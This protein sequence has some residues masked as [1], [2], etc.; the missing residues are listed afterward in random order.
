MLATQDSSEVSLDEYVT[1]LRRRWLWIVITPLIL[2]GF[3]LF[4]DLRAEPVYA[5]NA[6]ML[7]RSDVTNTVLSPTAA[8][9]DAER[10]LQNELSVINSRNVKEAVAE[11]YGKPISVRTLA[12]GEDDVIIL[13]AKASTGK[14]AAERAN[15]YATTYQSVR[16]ETL[17]Q[18][19][20]SAKKVIQQQ[21]DDF[22]AQ[23]DKINEPLRALDDEILKLSPDD[24]RYATLVNTRQQIKERTDA[25]RNEAQNQLNDYQQRLQILQLSERL[26][27]TGGIEILNPAIAPSTPVSPTVV[28]NLIQALVI[29]LFVGLG[30]AF[31]RDQLDDSLRTKAEVERA[32]RDVPTFALVPYDTTSG[33]ERHP[34]LS[35]LTAPM[36]AT[37]EAYRGLRTAIQYAGLSQPI[38]VMQITSASA[39]EAKTTTLSNLAMAF[40]L[41]GKR[42]AVMDC[43]LR[44]PKLHRFMQVDGT[45]GFTA[46]VLDDLPLEQAMQTS[47]L[48]PNVDVLP[49][50]YLPPNPSELLNH[51]RTSRII[52]SLAERYSMV[53]I[54]C[55]PVLPVTD[56]LVISRNVDATL[57]VTMA[58]KTSRRAA[59]RAA[60]MLRQV[61]A[62]LLATV[63]TGAA[64]RDTYVSLYEYYGYVQRSNI[65]VIG[66]FITRNRSDI[67]SA[68]QDM[69]PQADDDIELEPETTS[70]SS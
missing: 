61:G 44:K 59:K 42:V 19:L 38:K 17:L 41:S 60:E 62:P 68:T 30:L 67:P 7:L 45:K 21:I 69:L 4:Q 6:Q 58:N 66:R 28:R 49:A 20:T 18:G 70:E 14:A 33:D 36:S 26:T 47:P 56:A 64:D 55:P 15:I 31:L 65:P 11:A 40:A 50:G 35:T 43:D 29:G 8:P 1:V 34:K 53:F 52:E 23:V 48:H 32:V 63:I 27:T 39:S 46:V 3:S 51:E 16:L 13:Q 12:G 10:A 25:E 24:P 22:Q 5:A 37:A 54:D 2:G 57:F 9:Q